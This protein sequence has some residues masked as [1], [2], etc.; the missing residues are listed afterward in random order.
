M[1]GG[2]LLRPN[3]ANPERVIADDAIVPMPSLNVGDHYTGPIVG[4]MDYNFGN[5][6]VEVTNAVARVDGGLQRETTSAPTPAE[7]SIATFNFENLAATNA[8][9]KFDRLAAIV[10]T[11]LASPD[12]IAGE[13][14]Q[15]NNGA[16]DDGTVD[17]SQTLTRLVTAIQAAGGPAYAWRELDPVNDQDGGEPGGNIRQVILFRTDRGL[18]FVDRPGGTSTGS[19][20]VTG[21]GASTQ[22]IF[23]PGRIDPTSSAWSSSRKP[24]AGE[25]SFRGHKVFVVVNHFN[26]KGGDD[27][28]SGHFQPPVRSS[29]VQRH[30]QAQ[31]VAGF[32]SQIRSADPGA[33]VVV[34]GDLNDF[35]FSETVS[36]LE[37]AGLNDL[38]NR[39]P[40]DE[41]YSYEFEG[42]AQVLDHILVTQPLLARPLAFD[43]VHVNAEFF[44]QA[45]DHDPSV[46]RI[47]LDEPPTVDANGPYT[48]A[49]GGAVTLSAGATDPEGGALTYAWDLDDDGSFETAG[50]SVT[51]SAA[52]IDGPATRPVAV[53]A[54]DSSG[55][56]AVAATT[57][58]IANVAPTAALA[59]P[60]S[61][62]AGTS[63]TL[64]LTNPFDPSAADTA[65]GFAYSFDCGAGYGA[66]G[67][68]A[69]AT[70]ATSDSGTLSV[71]AKIADKDGGV[72][73]YAGS[74]S[75]VVTYASVCDLT[76]QL[77]SSSDVAAGLCA[78][79]E[80]AAAAAARGNTTAKAGQLEA[81]RNQVDAQTG[82]T[83][84]P[85]DAELL[86]R[87]SS[88]L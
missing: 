41:R 48:V 43:P 51:F 3:D 38:M 52:A 83:I 8:Q 58:T 81:Y 56:T 49:E 2:L 57:V 34:L 39:L 69:S 84:T 76:R 66:F 6:S 82:K 35:E 36:I 88:R 78:K 12:L 46:V 63:F 18:S 77:V 13:E 73:E 17:A 1:R 40:L 42:N 87:L 79:L 14:V 27:P 30:Q 21:S 26:S 74:V 19:T 28:L 11:N 15:D 47:A 64:A 50:Q 29:E 44:D 67:S 24:L 4:V 80:A 86:K 7:L 10:V 16:V 37:G 85:A 23:S 61:V 59:A 20:G 60:S 75:V 9:S 25:L 5:F 62:F 22:L 54:T 32:V 33:N 53:R 45:S 72:T 70:C 68:A 71:R 65:A 55:Q 31:L